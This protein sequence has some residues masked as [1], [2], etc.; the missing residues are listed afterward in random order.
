MLMEASEEINGNKIVGQCLLRL[1]CHVWV[2][3]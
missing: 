3:D 1:M 2:I